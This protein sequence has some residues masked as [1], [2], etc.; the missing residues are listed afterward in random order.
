MTA[1]VVSGLALLSSA[2]VDAKSATGSRVLVLLDSLAEKD[3]YSQFWQQLEGRCTTTVS[4]RVVAH[5]LCIRSPVSAL[6]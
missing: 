3:A 2:V 1:L 4:I 5:A 6:V